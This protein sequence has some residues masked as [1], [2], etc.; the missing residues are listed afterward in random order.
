VSRPHLG[1]RG[2][3]TSTAVGASQGRQVG[4]WQKEGGGEGGG[5]NG[6]Q[7]SACQAMQ[8]GKAGGEQGREGAADSGSRMDVYMTQE[9]FC[10]EV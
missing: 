7:A 3:D 6:S 1:L 2:S 5:D 8:G 4:R 9:G 10:Q